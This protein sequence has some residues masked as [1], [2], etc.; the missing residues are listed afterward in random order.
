MKLTL[1]FI[2]GVISII[3]N[4]DI[5][6]LGIKI[7]DAK[8]VLADIR[9]TVVDKER[10]MIKYT[11][12]NGNDFSVTMQNG[13]VVFMEND[14]LQNKK[15]TKPL[16]SNFIFGKTSL[17]DTR[18]QFGTNGFVHK[19]RGMFKTETAVILFNC[20]E[21]DS[22]NHEVL[23]T[24]TKVPLSAKPTDNNI[25]TLAMLDALIIADGNYLNEI[26]G[27]EKSYDANYVKIKP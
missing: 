20:F 22:P 4:T 19:N 21:F 15:A 7:G 14:W 3:V 1:L 18:A 8:N 27:A 26:W 13:K 5:S 24:I 9:L 11:T 2:A 10:D 17:A 23:V 25:A 16:F 12:D 6:M